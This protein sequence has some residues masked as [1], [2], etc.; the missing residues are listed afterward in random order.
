[1]YAIVSIRYTSEFVLAAVVEDVLKKILWCVQKNSPFYDPK[2]Q[3]ID[4][5]HFH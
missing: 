1:M 4:N 3:P 5:S 2:T